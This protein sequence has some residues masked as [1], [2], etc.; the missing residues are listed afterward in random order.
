MKQE[1]MRT[2]ASILAILNR[3][4]ITLPSGERVASIADTAQAASISYQS[5]HGLA[6]R[7]RIKRR[8]PAG[9]WLEIEEAAHAIATRKLHAGRPKI[10]TLAQRL[11]N[12][13]RRDE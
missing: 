12:H 5:V 9:Q 11:Q 7:G 4:A 10:L 1:E 13:D 6:Q 2:K 8:G 3:I